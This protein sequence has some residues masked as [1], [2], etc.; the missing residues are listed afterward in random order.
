MAEPLTFQ[1]LYDLFGA[2]FWYSPLPDKSYVATIDWPA[3]TSEGAGKVYRYLHYQLRYRLD[4][5]G[6]VDWDSPLGKEYYAGMQWTG[7]NDL[8]AYNYAKIEGL[9]SVGT[10]FKQAI[11]QGLST[12]PY[13]GDALQSV[14]EGAN[15]FKVL[16]GEAIT[17]YA[18][19]TAGDQL[20]AQVTAPAATATAASALP[21]TGVQTMETIA[22]NAPVQTF[23]GELSNII[24]SGFTTATQ[25]AVNKALAPPPPKVPQY[26]QPGY[27]GFVSTGNNLNASVMNVP[28][29]AWLLAGIVVVGGLVVVL[30]K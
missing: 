22:S 15:I 3:L 23:F 20:I 13:A 30:K 4:T 24:T 6:L 16:A 11:S 27:T 26:G 8:A 28:V 14:F 5:A 25:N 2:R 17:A 18:F 7:Q 19:T 10:A 29:W 12:V 1:E 21:T 9:A